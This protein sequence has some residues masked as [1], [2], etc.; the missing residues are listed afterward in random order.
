MSKLKSELRSGL[1][2]SRGEYYSTN[3][4]SACAEAF[5]NSELYKNTDVLLLYSSINSEPETSTLI[6]Q[7]IDDDKK[8]YL[9]RVSG[10][11]M[12]FYR[13][14]DTKSLVIGCFNISEPQIN[15]LKFSKKYGV[16][17]VPGLGFD[18]RGNRI[19]YGKG[20]YDKF[21]AK[22]PQLVKVGFCAGCNYLN[23]IPTDKF[24]IKMDFI[25]ADDILIGI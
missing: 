13:V 16:C 6:K 15:N 10:D 5:L 4:K 11:T 14:T 19:G 9:P 24:D 17:V 25:F 2:L 3:N 23:N 8:V 20:Y 1:K 12:D 21:L 22:N 18:H 7:A